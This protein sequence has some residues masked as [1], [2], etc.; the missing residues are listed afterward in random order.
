M[1]F[2]KVGRALFRGFR[3]RQ[4]MGYDHLVDNFKFIQSTFTSLTRKPTLGANSRRKESF[5]AA[6]ERLGLSEEDLQN[7]MG[8]AKKV[9]VLYF[10]LGLGILIYA[11]YIAIHQF[12]LTA[13][14]AFIVALIFLG[15][16]FRE[17]FNYFQMTQRRLGCTY[18]EW[19]IW[20][21]SRGRK[22]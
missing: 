15:Y 9:V 5:E 13:F 8:F 21:S 20:V 4:W 11:I 17:N 19:F 6:M 10:L 7:R 1:W 14:L 3:F 16:A 12:W 18:K 22:K 2:K